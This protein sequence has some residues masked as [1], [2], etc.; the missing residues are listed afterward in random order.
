MSP[1]S[2]DLRGQILSQT[3]LLE[4][5]LGSGGMGDVYLGRHLRTEGP[6][7]IKVLR[8]AARRAPDL[9]R[10]FQRE[11]RLLS[12]LRHPGF[13]Q[14]FDLNEDQALSGFMIRLRP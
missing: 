14:V 3:Y 6:V 7:A 9:Y 11:A 10:R 1:V 4:A 5:L 12:R 13:V 8:E 2:H